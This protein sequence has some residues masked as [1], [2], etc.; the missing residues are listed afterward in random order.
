MPQSTSLTLEVDSFQPSNFNS[1]DSTA[2]KK[3]QQPFA[4]LAARMHISLPA[5]SDADAGNVN[6]AVSAKQNP[7]RSEVSTRAQDVSGVPTSP[8]VSVST[9]AQ[10]ATAATSAPMHAS[11]YETPSAAVPVVTACEDQEILSLFDAA[12]NNANTAVPASHAAAAHAA[13]AAHATHVAHAAL[14]TL[15]PQIKATCAANS[16]VA[17]TETPPQENCACLNLDDVG[18]H[19]SSPPDANA[20]NSQAPACSTAQSS[21]KDCTAG[22]ATCDTS[23]TEDELLAALA[24]GNELY[25]LGLPAMTFNSNGNFEWSGAASGLFDGGDKHQIKA[26]QNKVAVTTLPGFFAYDNATTTFYLDEQ[27]ASMLGVEWK[28]EGIDFKDFLNIIRYVDRDLIM[29]FIQQPLG[30]SEDT[31]YFEFHVIKGPMCG[32]KYYLNT[33]ALV[34]DTNGELLLSSGFFSFIS[35]DTKRTTLHEMG[36]DGSWDWDGVTGKTHFSDSYKQM[37]GYEPDDPAFPPTFELWAKEL[38]H[39]DDRANTADK[40]RLVLASP[41]H[42][43]NFECCVRLKHKDGH[44]IWTLGRGMVLGRDEKGRALRLSGTNTDIE[45]V[46]YNTDITRTVSWTDKLT[47][48]QNRK[49]FDANRDNYLTDNRD[50]L[51]CLFAD[52]TGLKMLNDCLGHDEGDKLLRLAA[53]ALRGAYNLPCDIIRYGGDEFLMML[54]NCHKVQLEMLSFSV[55]GMCHGLSSEADNMPILIGCGVASLSEAN[56]DLNK[57]IALADQR[58]QEVK[59]AKRAENYRLLHAYIERRLGYDI[60]Y[61]DSRVIEI[62]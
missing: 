19:L 32:N 2:D 30:E 7:H 13:H 60:D 58:A 46:R 47:G 62:D 44:Y 51:C 5:D 4:A 8:D 29:R 21:S 55:E 56:G 54:P 48:L 57:M 12:V 41:E 25:T 28:S 23:A 35:T 52:V 37:L 31:M 18:E 45:Y 24:A 17:T 43:D 40:Q 14:M 34:R 26:R 27:A 22:A 20:L 42:G 10:E 16:A 38:V 1:G 3:N 49:Y 50:S 9:T 11:V 61:R 15:A 39:P 6:N 53:Q 59:N 33:G 36:K